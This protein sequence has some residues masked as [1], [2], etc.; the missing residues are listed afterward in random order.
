MPSIKDSQVNATTIIV[1]LILLLVLAALA[2]SIYLQVA[3]DNIPIA[4]LCNYNSTERNYVD[5]DHNCV[6]N[7][8][9]IQGTKA[10]KDNC[11]CGCEKISNTDQTNSSNSHKVYCSPD[12]KKAQ[13]CPEYYSAT[14]G[15]FSTSI[16]CIK[17]PCAQT[18]SNPCFAC[19]DPKVSYY[20]M[21]ECP[22]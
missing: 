10:F 2:F 21:G 20:T 14:C 22:K 6:V 16:K 4:P 1:S 7:F 11:G 3:N 12:S 8:F 17:Y 19:A 15:W 5:T 9:C 18:F 13:V